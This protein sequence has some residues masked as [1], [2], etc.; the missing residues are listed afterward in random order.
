MC[1]QDTQST[2]YVLEGRR[3][4]GTTAQQSRDDPKKEHTS[5]TQLS[6]VRK[7]KFVYN[8]TVDSSNR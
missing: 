3:D 4:G 2:I 1:K 8:Y 6:E 7:S 5:R